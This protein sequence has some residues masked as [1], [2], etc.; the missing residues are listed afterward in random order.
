[1]ASE[2]AFSRIETSQR[3]SWDWV[4]LSRK[5]LSIYHTS[6]LF[7]KAIRLTMRPARM[8]KM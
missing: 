7:G 8:N 4:V 5:T 3:Q 2:G 1:M 6:D